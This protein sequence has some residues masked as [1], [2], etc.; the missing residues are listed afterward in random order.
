MAKEHSVSIEFSDVVRLVI[1]CANC[2]AEIALALTEDVAHFPPPYCPV[3]NTAW[4]TS[5]PLDTY[6]GLVNGVIQAFRCFKSDAYKDF[7]KESGAR[8]TL[9]LVIEGDD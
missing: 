8:W 6:T 9:R 2:K 4:M 5:G 3:C 1:R 7:V